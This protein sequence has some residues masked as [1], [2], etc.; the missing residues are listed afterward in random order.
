MG[1]SETLDDLY[2]AMDGG[3]TAFEA[4]DL[5]GWRAVTHAEAWSFQGTRFVAASEFFADGSAREQANQ[6][7]DW[8][9]LWR[10]GVIEGDTAA[11]WGEVEWGFTAGDVSVRLRLGCSWTQ[12][13]VDGQWLCL[14]SHYT[15]R[16][17]EVLPS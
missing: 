2:A 8:T 17:P 4:G 9:I 16:N 5:D 11:V 15:I 14:F 3:Q 6:H 10:D 12:V 7:A 13:R 1:D